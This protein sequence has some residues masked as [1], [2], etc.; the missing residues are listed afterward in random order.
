MGFWS[1]LNHCSDAKRD[2][3]PTFATSL[4]SFIN[5]IHS[6]ENKAIKEGTTSIN[7]NNESSH[8]A[9]NFAAICMILVRKICM[10]S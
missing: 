4:N 9:S 8:V 10:K 5:I 3:F 7:S 6:T 2:G 1:T